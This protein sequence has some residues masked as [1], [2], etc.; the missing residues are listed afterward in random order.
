MLTTIRIVTKIILAV[1][2]HLGSIMSQEPHRQT[3]PFKP[4][5]RPF[6][7]HLLQ[8]V[9]TQVLTTAVQPH[10]NW[11][12]FHSSHSPSLNSSHTGLLAV[13]LTRSSCACLRTFALALEYTSARNA[14]PPEA[15]MA[16]SPPSALRSSVA[17]LE[18][19]PL[20]TLE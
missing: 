6:I 2:I 15:H 11:P 13:S 10:K 1:V 9:T 19:P 3:D 12:S 20:T 5:L 18:R 16:P 4:W 17:S 8:W 7:I 14:L